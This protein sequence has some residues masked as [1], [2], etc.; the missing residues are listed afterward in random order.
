VGREVTVLKAGWCA[1]D[2]TP[3]VGTP[4]AGFAARKGV[5]EG[6]HD[7]L[8]AR[9]L[10]IEREGGETVAL[11]T[12][13]VVGMPTAMARQVRE[14]IA[15]AIGITPDH[16][17]VS[18]SH[19]HSGPVL[20][21]SLDTIGL[22]SEH[23]RATLAD[24]IVGAA[25]AAARRREPVR[26]EVAS[27]RIEGI[28]RNRRHDDGL[29]VDPEVGLL[30]LLPSAGPACRFVKYACHAVTLGPDNLL[31]TA[32][33]P[34][35]A[36]RFIER[37]MGPG[38]VAMFANG[39]AGDVNTGHSADLSALGYFIP[40]RTFERAERLGTMLGAEV[41]R[42]AQ[43]SEAE[44]DPV[45]RAASREI[46]LPAKALPSIAEATADLERKRKVLDALSA[47]LGSAVPET[48]PRLVKARV[49]ELYARLLVLRV[50]QRADT[51]SGTEASKQIPVEIQGIR[52][53]E[54][55][56]IGVPVEL[57]VEIGLAVKAASPWKRTWVLGY[58]NGSM[59]YLPSREAYVEGGYEVVSSIFAPEAVT[60]LEQAMIE[61][62]SSLK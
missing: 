56:L 29:P 53:G 61:L 23:Y 9:A 18:A 27:G 51:G 49:D 12:A 50:G 5:S 4:L 13:D 8:K 31:I 1:V 21:P 17:M 46:L 37:V 30:S 41:V 60:A 14:R 58:T 22:A 10:V 62:A 55:A 25:A 34:G 39:A 48:D 32:D 16:V 54:T 42:T 52:I 15:T 57:F 35:Y 47:K 36:M 6:I 26:L 19:T 11:L 43:T 59:G 28:G 33:Y 45:V 7:P 44:S 24:D 2:I 40:G 3:P 20:E 38:T